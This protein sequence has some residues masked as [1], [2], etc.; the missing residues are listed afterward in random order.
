[1]I[2]RRPSRAQAM[3]VN[4]S[5]DNLAGYKEAVLLGAA[6]VPKEFL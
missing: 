6:H 5:Q 1:M 3:D 2:P 4:S